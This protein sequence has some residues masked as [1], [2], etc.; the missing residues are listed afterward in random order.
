MEL[1][2]C[3][4]KIGG[5]CGAVLD[6]LRSEARV[7]RFLYLF[8]DDDSYERLEGAMGAGDDGE[9][10]RAAHTLKGVSQNL[11]FT[12]LYEASAALTEALRGGRKG[13]VS[14]LAERV[15]AEYRRT[16]AAIRQM[17]REKEE[18]G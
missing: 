9:A 16:A 5:D 17:Q 7:E 2:E 6:H 8:L 14:E 18:N 4:E 3:Y 15:R 10:F 1:R 12:R 11:C 13:D